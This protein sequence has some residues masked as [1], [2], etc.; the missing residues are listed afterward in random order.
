MRAARGISQ[1]SAETRRNHPEAVTFGREGDQ[2]GDVHL[3][4]ISQFPR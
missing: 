1:H 4:G 3:A 2:V